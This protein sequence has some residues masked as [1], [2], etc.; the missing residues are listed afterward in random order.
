[1]WR[2]TLIVAVTMATMARADDAPIKD[3]RLSTFRTLYQGSGF[4][5]PTNKED[6]QKRAEYLR[7]QVL[8]AAGLWP[9]PPKPELKAV[10]HGKVERDDYTV[11]KVFFQSHPGFYVTGNLYRPKGKTGPF[12]GVLSP[13]GH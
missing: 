13:H 8:I 3:A 6:W 11:E 10:I 12:P 4:T 9:M 2:V 5:P 7:Q 1:M